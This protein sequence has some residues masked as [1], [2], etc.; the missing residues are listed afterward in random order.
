MLFKSL[1]ILL[2]RGALR[3]P[4]L[5]SISV[6]M[7]SVFLSSLFAC[8][9]VLTAADSAGIIVAAAS[10]LTPIEKQMKDLLPAVPV[11]FVFGSSGQLANQ[12]RAGAPYD[13]YLSASLEFV[14]ALDKEGLLVVGTARAF[15]RGRL[16]L[17]A[18]DAGLKSLD[19]LASSRAIAIANPAHAPYGIAARQVLRARPD[20]EQAL[21]AKIVYAENVRQALQFAESGNADVALVA[22]SLVKGRPGAVLLPESLH[23]PIV[24]GV[25]VIRAQAAEAER[26]AHAIAFVEALVSQAGQAMLAEAG[27][28]P[29][30][31][32]RP[33]T[34]AAPPKPPTP[35]KPGAKK[36]RRRRR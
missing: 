33:S 26:S 31:P 30:S 16:A 5:S 22:W 17:Y 35:S 11:R 18:K 15:A 25:G 29:A 4:L 12:I 2:P 23:S 32:I 10:D 20:W 24:Q 9:A 14:R 6:S 1:Q 13:V 36:P 28:D 34:A 3:L 8:V 21:S 19:Q 7:L 27:F